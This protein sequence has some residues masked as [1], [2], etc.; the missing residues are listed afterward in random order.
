MIGPGNE[1][2]AELDRQQLRLQRAQVEKYPIS[3]T[4]IE[5]MCY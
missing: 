1:G 3:S 2:T 4:L 5:K